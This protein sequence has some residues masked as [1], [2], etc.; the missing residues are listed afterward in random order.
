MKKAI[1]FLTV[2]IFI[3]S[4]AVGCK[5]SEVNELK[6]QVAELSE[7][8]AE[9]D[10]VDQNEE[11]EELRGGEESSS[12]PWNE[13]EYHIGEMK[14][15]YGSVLDTSYIE[16]ED[17]GIWLV[18]GKNYLDPKVF[19]VWIFNT[20]ISK[21]SQEPEIYYLGKNISVTGVIGEFEGAAYM[22][23]TDPDQIEESS[24][25]PWNEAEYHIGEIVTVHGPVVATYYNEVIDGGITFLNIGKDY[26][27]PEGFS[28]WI[29]SPN[30]PN[31]FKAPEIYYSGKNIS[32][33]GFIVEVDGLP[34]MEIT[35]S[36]Q[37]SI[38]EAVEEEPEEEVVEETVEES[39]EGTGVAPTIRLEIIEGPAF[40]QLGDN[41]CYYR[42]KAHITG[43]PSP[44]ISFNKD[45]SLGSLGA[46][47]SQ[48]N[49]HSKGDSFTLEATAMN[50]QGSV[51]DSITLSHTCQDHIPI[52]VKND[53]GGTLTLSISGPATYNFSI[54][55]GH[56]NIYVIPGTYNYTGKGCG[57]GVL[58][59]TYDLSK[60]GDEWDW[61]CQ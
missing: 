61:W 52:L 29:D 53:T 20:N 16:N 5:N 54:P 6:E 8:L 37:I 2:L 36:D 43:N 38:E 26:P 13:A 46:N 45:D 11:A 41:T 15:V 50:S 47:I 12:I 56:Q 21:F 3:V 32:V 39:V 23:V 34:L 10:L 9:E 24:S 35:D 28:V 33:L 30:R 48:V 18:F 49:L 57:G 7:N 19:S 4:F 22:E 27:D 14:T 25:I 31:F 1:L 55:P 42:V 40:S 58:S 60:S 51:S 17:G 44:V 59:G